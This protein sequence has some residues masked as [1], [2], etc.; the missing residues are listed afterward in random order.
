MPPSL[1]SLLV[2]V[3]ALTSQE[4]TVT[5]ELIERVIETGGV[6]ATVRVTNASPSTLYFGGYSSTSPVYSVESRIGGEWEKDFQGW[7]GTGLG[8]Q[9]LAAGSSFEFL[10]FQNGPG[11][12]RLGITTSTSAR[13]FK[14]FAPN[15][16]ARPKRTRAW[17]T[18]PSDPRFARPEHSVRIVLELHADQLDVCGGEVLDLFTVIR[19]TSDE[20]IAV[21]TPGSYDGYVSYGNEDRSIRGHW[22]LRGPLPDRRAP[23]ERFVRLEPG[24]AAI[25]HV[26]LGGAVPLPTVERTEVLDTS[27]FVA[28]SYAT[29]ID[30]LSDDDLDRASASVGGA[31]IVH[32]RLCMPG[33]AFELGPPD[34]SDART[35]TIHARKTARAFLRSIETRAAA[36]DDMSM[37]AADDETLSGELA[38]LD[39]RIDALEIHALLTTIGDAPFADDVAVA[40]A[41]GRA[42]N[43]HPSFRLQLLLDVIGRFPGST[44]ALQAA[45]WIAYPDPTGERIRPWR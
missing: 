12:K 31:G 9:Q 32:E 45:E 37:S 15:A 22:T 34:E 2:P 4:P 19:N 18:I 29:C 7:C 10:A 43:D 8:E 21:P 17:G 25:D 3:L 11:E 33:F 28:R 30:G 35:T 40:F 20:P 24:E 36:R 14:P 6:S 38:L 26:E 27:L 42:W 1:A 13:T 39:Y 16:G 23:V 44:G 41:L 5:I